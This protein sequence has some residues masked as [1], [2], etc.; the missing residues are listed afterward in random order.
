M[1]KE[2]G[3][4]NAFRCARGADTLNMAISEACKTSRFRPARRELRRF[5]GAQ[6]GDTQLR[7]PRNSSCAGFD[8]LHGHAPGATA[9]TI[10]AGSFTRRCARRDLRD[11]GKSFDGRGNYLR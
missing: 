10:P 11:L 5:T 3:Y 7:R 9:C 2:F 1:M 4:T 6:A 8:R